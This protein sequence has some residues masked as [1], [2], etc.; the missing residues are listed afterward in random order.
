MWYAFVSVPLFQFLLLRWYY[1]I[2]IWARFLWQVSQIQLRLVPTHPDHLGG[3]GFL[4]MTSSAFAP[5]A[6]AHGAL[7]SGWIAT[8][9]FHHGAALLDF[10]VEIVAVAV[11][12]LCLVFAPFLVFSRHLAHF[13]RQGERDYGPLAE[14]YAHQFEAKWVAGSP[15]PREA[16]LGTSDIQ[17][18]SDMG[19]VYDVVHTMR[20]V[21]FTRQGAVQVLAATLAPIAPLLLT[22][23]P[24][25]ELVRQL[26]KM[27]L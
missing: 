23:M 13:W 11:V 9:I 5:L 1:R 22:M 21:P 2:F 6:A 14:R 8:R 18:L 24:L 10:K 17:S 4:S 20:L 19:H 7:V 27:V 16:L 12:M 3:L 15:P 26:A 25:G